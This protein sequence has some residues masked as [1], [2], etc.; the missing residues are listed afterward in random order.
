MGAAVDIGAT[1]EQ[2]LGFLSLLLVLRLR[3]WETDLFM[4]ALG[5]IGLARRSGS[6]TGS[7]G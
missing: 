2:V 6:S 5:A 1:R 4:Q 7:I 3:L